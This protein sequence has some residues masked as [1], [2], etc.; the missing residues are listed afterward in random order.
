MQ[1]QISSA[2][3]MALLAAYF[4]TPLEQSGS[5]KASLRVRCFVT[6]EKTVIERGKAV[7]VH[8]RIDNASQEDV[9]ISFMSAYLQVRQRSNSRE[10][11]LPVRRYSSAVDVETASALRLVNDPK[12]AWSYPERRLTLGAGKEVELTLDLASLEWTE[13]NAAG[14]PFFHLFGV[15]TNGAY[16]LDFNLDGYGSSGKFAIT[17][18][19][20]ILEIQDLP[21]R[22]S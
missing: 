2:L 14:L 9:V 7:I 18:S 20:T 6:T 15:V 13:S 21:K 3:I 17:S 11:Y 4:A 10:P 22:T 8:V 5:V 19:K 1:R 16:E 12:T